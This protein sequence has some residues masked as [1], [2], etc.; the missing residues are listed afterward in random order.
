MLL[1]SALLLKSDIEAMSAFIKQ[2]VNVE[3]ILFDDDMSNWCALTASPDNRVSFAWTYLLAYA[4]LFLLMYKGCV[5]CDVF[6][7][8]GAW[9]AAWQAVQSCASGSC[10]AGPCSAFLDV[11][12][13]KTTR[14]LCLVGSNVGL[15]FS[16]IG[17]ISSSKKKQR[18]AAV[19]RGGVL[20]TPSY[21]AQ[22]QVRRK[23]SWCLGV[24]V[25][26]EESKLI[27]M[28]FVKVLANFDLP[29]ACE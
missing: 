21:F 8:A 28:S 29:S 15:I 27:D 14:K 9:Q 3:N 20:R 5:C 11:L 7:C 19:W 24:L 10:K 25:S 23:V 26:F 13:C 16:C 2:E 6:W 12:G 4:D 1:L 17:R 18:Y 22:S